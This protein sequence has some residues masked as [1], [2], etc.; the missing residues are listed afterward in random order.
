MPVLDNFRPQSQGAAGNLCW[1]CVGLSVAS[2]Y[3]RLKGNPLRWTRLCEYVMAVLAAGSGSPGDC[4]DSIRLFDNDCN[5]P[6]FV[7]DALDVSNNRG[8]LRDDPLSYQEIQAEINGKQPV[9][10]DIETSVGSHAV[11]I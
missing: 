7:P 9:G 1:A 4:C 3:D 10:V 5:Q 2:Y 11:V 6:G 8:Q